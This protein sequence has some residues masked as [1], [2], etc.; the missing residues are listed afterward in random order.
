MTIDSRI[1]GRDLQ[2]QDPQDQDIHQ[3]VLHSRPTNLI[4]VGIDGT[5]GSKQAARWAAA[6]AVRRHAP[7]RLVSAYSIPIGMLEY[8]AVDDGTISWLRDGLELV[9]T[10][11]TEE[12]TAAHPGLEISGIVAEASPMAL[13]RRES[14]NT[15]M[16]VVATR[17]S[18][19][20]LHVVLGS[21]ALGAA[22]ECPAPVVVIRPGAAM[23]KPD[24]PVVVGI[25]GSPTSELAV[26]FA[27]E[28]AAVRAAPLLAVHSWNDNFAFDVAGTA[29]V[30][31]RVN[32]ADLEEDERE[33]L[34]ERLAGWRDKYPDV[35]VQQTVVRGRPTENLLRLSE[36]AQLLV[37][38]SRGR[39][40]LV[41]ALLGSTSHALITH[42]VC[43]VAVVKPAQQ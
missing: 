39:S 12:L 17:D 9:Q 18:G 21:V 40:G 2:G 8:A 23:P 42:S 43:P 41:G 20:L 14:E 28:A 3:P 5:A 24:A 7:L 4:V 22:S 15:A 36:N 25:D 38:G 10:D 6:E 33:V 32:V 34:S 31:P 26:A 37:V 13:L 35:V 30:G 11:I 27:F 19:R 16:L 29:E 1:Q